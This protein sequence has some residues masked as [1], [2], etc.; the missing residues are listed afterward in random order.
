MGFGVEN[1]A[2]MAYLAVFGGIASLTVLLTVFGL[3]V[4]RAADAEGF[5]MRA[6]QVAA[7]CKDLLVG[8][9]FLWAVW[10]DTGKAA[11]MKVLVRNARDERVCTIT[12]PSVPVDGVLK[13]FDLDGRCYEISKAGLMSNR[14]CLREA[15]RT[16][17]LLSAV[18]GMLETIFFGGDAG[19]VIF[20]LPTTSVLTR[21]RPCMVGEQEIG[22]LIIGLEGSAYAR[23]I[24]MPEGRCSRL[25]QVFVLAGS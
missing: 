11:A 3:R 7:Q 10:Q 6:A 24:T 5:A 12:V 9:D 16:A 1:Q 8:P 14:T 17:V 25:E 19:R 22:K 13:R 23:V 20:V 2:P 4:R 15:G 18:H 21:F